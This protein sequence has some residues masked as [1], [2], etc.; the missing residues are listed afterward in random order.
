MFAFTYFLRAKSDLCKYT[1]CI[2]TPIKYLYLYKTA[3]IARRKNVH[4]IMFVI[5][6]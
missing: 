5:E 2:L 6:F 3:N 1:M 4:T